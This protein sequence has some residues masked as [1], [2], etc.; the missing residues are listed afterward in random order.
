MAS[1]WEASWLDGNSFAIEVSVVLCC[2][3]CER[4]VIT[5]KQCPARLT[6]H[7]MAGNPQIVF[8]AMRLGAS[9]GSCAYW[10]WI[11]WEGSPMSVMGRRSRGRRSPG[12]RSPGR[13]GSTSDRISC[14]MRAGAASSSVLPVLPHGD[15]E[16]LRG[17]FPWRFW[18]PVFM[19]ALPFH[20]LARGSF[21]GCWAR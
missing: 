2:D 13:R 17:R 18:R 6:D 10:R 7:Q 4:N 12:W 11:R 15:G 16:G 19:A 9:I 3:S 8:G 5:V 14:A 21:Q 20:G 1:S